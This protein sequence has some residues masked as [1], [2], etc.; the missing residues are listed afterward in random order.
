MDG[1]YISLAL[2]IIVSLVQL[3]ALFVRNYKLKSITKI[4]LLPLII[5]YYLFATKN[6]NW[7]LLSALLCGWIGDII[8]IPRK[9]LAVAIGGWFFLAEQLL[10]ST[11]I[12]LQINY[13]NINI[14]WL[15]ILPILYVTFALV[16]NAKIIKKHINLPLF[17]FS[18]GY[19]A[20]TGITASLSIC[21]VISNPNLS[22]GLLLMGTNIFFISDTVLEYVRMADN[23]KFGTRHIFIMTT[24]VLAQFLIAFSLI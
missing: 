14:S 1:K 5:S 22:T 11:I 23:P 7:L 2:L 20:V 15:I 19:L 8:L 12:G 3:Y 4:F 18:A 13:S 21:L 6:I 9:K 10:L 24:Y 17:I 16:Y